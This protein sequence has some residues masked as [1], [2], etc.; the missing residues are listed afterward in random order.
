MENR[1]DVTTMRID[2]DVLKK[3]K[4]L[5][6]ENDITNSEVIR[7]LVDTY[8]SIK[9]ESQNKSRGISESKEVND[10]EKNPIQED[11][12]EMSKDIWYFA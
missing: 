9:I 3:L 7:F 2:R 12:S 6:I 5:A 1:N 11:V 10:T 8:Y 4:H